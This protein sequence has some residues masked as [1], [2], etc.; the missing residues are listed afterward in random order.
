MLSR[1]SPLVSAAL[2]LTLTLAGCASESSE[3]ADAALRD[4]AVAAAPTPQPDLGEPGARATVHDT[5]GRT[6]GTAT[7]H[8]T[9]SSGVLVRL[10]LTDA[11]PGSHAFHFHST[12]SCEPDFMAAGG[13]FNAGGG[14]HGILNPD[15]RHTG[16]LPNVHV[17][18][19]RALVMDVLAPGVTLEEERTGTLFDDDGSAIMLHQGPD[20]YT[21]PPRGAD[22]ERMACG[23]I[24]R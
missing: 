3:G 5:A 23:V 14:S 12:G 13:H 15:G 16:D 22:G 18:A 9:P 19:S 1:P 8:E 4:S 11:E 17:P 6:V 10:R 21:R 24:T 7:L 20:P 2:A